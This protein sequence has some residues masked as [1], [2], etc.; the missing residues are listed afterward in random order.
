MTVL[1]RPSF[2]EKRIGWIELS[3]VIAYTLLLLIGASWIQSADSLA[4]LGTL[5]II[6]VALISSS[7]VCCRLLFI[8][9][10]FFNIM[11]VDLGGTSLFYLIVLLF[12]VK[13][14]LDGTAE[15]AKRRL[16]PF[17]LIVLAT[18]YNFTAGS[19]YLR[20]LMHLLFPVAFVSTGRARKSFP[21]YMQLLTLSLAI[22]AVLGQVMMDAGVYIY[23]QG[24]VWME[25]G[26]IT[27]FAGLVGDSVFYGQVVAVVV[28]TN[29][30]LALSGH[31][32]RLLTPLCLWLV[33]SVFLTYS[34]GALA[35][36]AVIACF[37]IL[38][39]LKRL[40]GMGLLVRHVLMCLAALVVGYWAVNLLLSGTSGFSIAALTTRLGA[41]DLLTGRREIWEGYFDIWAHIGLPLIFRGMGFDAYAST[42]VYKDITHCHSIYVE[43]VTLFGLIGTAVMGVA[44]LRFVV[45]RLRCGSLPL[46]LIPCI[47]LLISGL[48]LHGFTDAP[49]FYAWTVALCCIDY[50]RLA[51][52]RASSVE[53]GCLDRLDMKKRLAVSQARH[54]P[55]KELS[56]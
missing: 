1:S 24:Y 35:C 17:V 42:M 36:L 28:G 38:G 56:H 26:T 2:L 11:G 19:M 7:E 45:S 33:I 23:E 25:S 50:S 32:Y 15:N 34:K 40:L 9:F 48:T 47:V 46:S 49:F 4:L 13:S 37:L 18:L 54:H 6:S 39:Y 10:P 51:D 16:V 29:V 44:L 12:A 5:C 21:V 27:R 43:A 14:L 31:G 52:G 41:G 3:T 55:W 53:A 22:S 8:C 30:Y 20:W